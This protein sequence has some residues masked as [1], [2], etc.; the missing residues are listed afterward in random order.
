M[1]DFT[2]IERTQLGEDENPLLD[3]L[4]DTGEEF[5]QA[6]CEL[7]NLYARHFETPV[8]L[9]PGRSGILH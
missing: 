9:A 6:F 5:L 2:T 8:V 7:L 4:D 1:L 3:V